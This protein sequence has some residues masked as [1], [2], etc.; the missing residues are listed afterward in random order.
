MNKSI[1]KMLAEKACK[2]KLLIF[3]GAGASVG[4]SSEVGLPSG[5][6]LNQLIIDYF[7]EKD[8][9]KN[10][11]LEKVTEYIE[12]KYGRKVLIDKLYEI[13]R[14]V[15]IPLKTHKLISELPVKIFVTTNYDELL[16][17]ALKAINKECYRIT[18]DSDI[19][20]ISNN[21]INIF[22]IH[23]CVTTK[24]DDIIITESDYYEKFLLKSNLY[25]DILKAWL[26]T[27]T[28]LFIGY[29]LSDVNLKYLFFEI[30][31]KIGVE[32]IKGRFY[33]IQRN[34]NKSDIEIWEKRGFIILPE[35][36]NVFLDTLIEEIEFKDIERQNDT[37]VSKPSLSI[38]KLE[39]GEVKSYEQRNGNDGQRFILMSDR[40]MNHLKVV[41]GDWL[42]IEV[43]NNEQI[44]SQ[45][46]RVY[47]DN[48]VSEYTIRLPLV[49]R[50]LL[51]VNSDST[52]GSNI[53]LTISKAN[54]TNISELLIDSL[55]E[56][57]SYLPI[58]L[59]N[60]NF[61]QEIPIIA[62]RNLEFSIFDLKGQSNCTVKVKGNSEKTFK[63][64]V[65]LFE[66]KYNPGRAI[67]G[68]SS[69]FRR[70]LVDCGDNFILNL[71]AE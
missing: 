29:S 52:I 49:T 45:L 11:S 12:K 30:S 31:K 19:T 61:H 47:H 66:S 16:E 38:G 25:I 36:K 22:K 2:N 9:L 63:A 5:S 56:S 39:L 42:K 17:K 67:V 60:D 24:E 33:A 18:S 57:I 1:Y 10:E 43:Q 4:S 28:C 20:S 48:S 69:T 59:D 6:Q 44:N 35:D 7:E 26:S 41:D 53:N 64:K 70:L 27:H 71:K 68:I 23:G 58:E 15:S 46:A 32:N 14:S 13:V 40:K 34:P 54:I 51:K 50:N 62:L 3:I 55:K 37:L 8:I 65:V 21:E